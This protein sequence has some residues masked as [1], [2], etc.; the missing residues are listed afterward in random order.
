MRRVALAAL[1]AFATGA[2]RDYHSY[3]P[4]ADQSGLIP[5]DQFARYGQQQAEAVAIGRAL[6]AWKMTDD[7]AGKQEQA[8][9]AAC[10]ARRFG[11]VE[12]VDVDP[13]GYRLTVK[14]AGGWRV[15]IV[16]IGDGVQPEATK[17][18]SALGPSPCT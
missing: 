14:F 1:A 9:R 12:S 11:D 7:E 4:L 8:S 18:I 5:A 17:G 3:A 2:C 16:P 6:A 10:F 13:A 15:G